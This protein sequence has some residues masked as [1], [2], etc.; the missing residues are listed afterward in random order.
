MLYLHIDTCRFSS[1]IN[2]G[3][4]N[5]SSQWWKNCQNSIYFP[6]TVHFSGKSSIYTGTDRKMYKDLLQSGGPNWCFIYWLHSYCQ[7]ASGSTAGL[8]L[9][10][11]K[12][13]LKW[14]W[15]CWVGPWWSCGECCPYKAQLPPSCLHGWKRVSCSELWLQAWWNEWVYVCG[16][17]HSLK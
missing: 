6:R 11:A 14:P 5:M 2:P 13:F 15:T 3:T 7:S 16:K 10:K 17:I 12:I 8:A 1:E 9:A 4:K